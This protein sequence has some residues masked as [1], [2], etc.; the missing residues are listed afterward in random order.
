MG[1]HRKHAT[2]ADRQR[3]YRRRVTKN[4]AKPVTIP[5]FVQASADDIR[6][7]YD[8]G[9]SVDFLRR[10]FA[11]QCRVIRAVLDATPSKPR[12]P[13]TEAEAAE[14]R[15]TLETLQKVWEKFPE[16]AA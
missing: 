10:R 2:N 14:I 4:S 16:L 1:R 5:W 8:A 3:A 7:A 12:V 15:Q 6:S 13:R 11:T 9:C